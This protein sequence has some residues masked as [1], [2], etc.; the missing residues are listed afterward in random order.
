M[1]AIRN[2]AYKSVG[3]V[4]GF[5]GLAIFILIFG[6]SFDPVFAARVG[7]VTGLGITL[8]LF[9]SAYRAKIKPYDKT[10][11]WL[12]LPEPDRPPAAVAQKLVGDALNDSYLWFARQGAVVTGVLLVISLVLQFVRMGKA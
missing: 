10:H 5:A 6:L 7:A 11:L 2:A 1:D 9:G 4:C 12:M 3:R 8:I